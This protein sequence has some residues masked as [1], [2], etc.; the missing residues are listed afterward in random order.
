MCTGSG[1]PERRTTLNL[2]GYFH[3]VVDLFGYFHPVRR[4][5][6]A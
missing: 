4:E 6:R 1:Q 2:F 5:L 3:P